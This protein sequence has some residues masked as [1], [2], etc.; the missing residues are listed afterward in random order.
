MTLPDT[1]RFKQEDLV[2]KVTGDIDPTIFDITKYE[3]FIES[4]CGKR[5]FQAEAIRQVA[6]FL[7]GG[8]YR[9]LRALAEENFNSNPNLREKYGELKAFEEALEFP[10]QLACSLDLATGTGKSYVMYGLARIAL[11]E[12]KVDRVLLLCPSKT[13][14]S[15]LTQKFLDLSKDRDLTSQLPRNS[16]C[17]N[18]H[19][20]NASETTVPGSI[21]IEN[22]HAT[23][24]STKS[25][26]AASFKGKGGTTLVLCDEAHHILTPEGDYDL[27]KWKEFLLSPEYGFKYIV[28]LSGTCYVGD[29]YFRDVI[30]R[31]S[32]RQAIKDGVVKDV[33]YVQ[34]DTSIDEYQKFQKIYDNHKKAKS[35]Y[36]EVKPLTV[37]VTKDIPAC[38]TLEDDLV[39][40]LSKHEKLSREA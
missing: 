28:G 18:P 10:N 35:E 29:E 9:D 22:I 38:K 36:R 4:L 14:E 33:W 15:G 3:P 7:F 21:C 31:Y 40:F 5:E 25:S 37:I 17:K 32:L 6:N 1:T 24:S 11:A 27:R 8:S 13:I 34:E 30:S 2:L 39:S 19:L 20:V 23:Y 12:G 26:I 16:K